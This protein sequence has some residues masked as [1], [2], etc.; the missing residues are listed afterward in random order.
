MIA[1]RTVTRHTIIALGIVGLSAGA[2]MSGQ[3]GET[4]TAGPKAAAKTAEPNTAASKPISSNAKP[5]P[6]P[7]AAKAKEQKMLPPI[8]NRFVAAIESET[9]SFRRHVVP[10]LGKLG[11]N[12]R[13]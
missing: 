7:T 13:A 2:V 5:T 3:A 4:P 11:C 10:L 6:S 9:P 12:G 1:L 8:S